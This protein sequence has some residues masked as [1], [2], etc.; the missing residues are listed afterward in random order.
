LNQPQDSILGGG[1]DDGSELILAPLESSATPPGSL[2]PASPATHRPVTEAA[3]VK[4]VEFKSSPTLIVVTAIVGG[5]LAAAFSVGLFIVVGLVLRGS[6]PAVAVSSAENSSAAAVDSSS[7]VPDAVAD[8]QVDA[9]AKASV[10]S[11]KKSGKNSRSSSSP[12]KA[13]PRETLR[14]PSTRSSASG[15]STASN[16]SKG[17]IQPVSTPEVSQD[18]IER[19]KE[20]TVFVSVRTSAG[21]QSGSGFLL[22]KDGN[23]GIVVTNAHVVTPE[24]GTLK[25]IECV[26]HSGTRRE[27]T[28]EANIKGQDDAADL[29]VLTV[30]HQNLPEPLNA[31]QEV[32]LRE[33]LPV[34]ILGFP[35]GD[36]LATTG[37]RPSISVSKVAISSIRRDAYDNV[38]LLQI[39]GGINPGN[40]G[41]PIVTEDGHL[42]GIAVAKVRDA[43]IGF[44]IP[45]SALSDLVFGRVARVAIRQLSGDAES[46]QY[47]VTVDLIDPRQNIQSV[48]MLAFYERGTIRRPGPETIKKPGPDGRWPRVS[49]QNIEQKLKI[50]GS[51]AEGDLTLPTDPNQWHF[52]LRYVG[53]DRQERFTQPAAFVA[54]RSWMASK[55]PSDDSAKPRPGDSIVPFA[56]EPGVHTIKLPAP[57]TEADVA[58]GGKYLILNLPSMRK[59]A[60]LDLFERKLVKYLDVGGHG[61]CTAGADKLIFVLPSQGLIQRWSLDT[62]ER[63]LVLPLEL[64]Y[65]PTAAVM[66]SAS[67]GPVLIGGG[68]FRQGFRLLD[69][70]TLKPI[71]PIEEVRRHM[72]RFEVEDHCGARASADGRVFTAWKPHVSPT[73]FRVLVVDGTKLESFHEH[74]TVGVIVPNADG[75]MLFTARGTYT[76][77]I[78][79]IGPNDSFPVPA[80][81][82]NLYLRIERINYVPG[83]KLPSLSV[84]VSGFDG[85]L[86]TLS[87]VPMQGA[88]LSD[89]FARDQ[90]ALDQRIYFVPEA[91][92]I[93]TLPPTNDAVRLREF[94]VFKELENSPVEYLFVQS[95][96]PRRATVGVP[97]EYQLRVAS[98]LGDVSFK[99]EA[100]PEGMKI[101]EDGKLTWTPTASDSTAQS[102]IILVSDASGREIFHSFLVNVVS[103]RPMEKK[104]AE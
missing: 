95:S 35:F 81:Q 56:D 70:D 59:L 8:S 3:S 104:P 22:E 66:G 68:D 89:F 101:S 15:S 93:A 90:I 39:D 72:T 7:S 98:K 102:V 57:Y 91:K 100:G 79:L 12:G 34:L 83:Q 20:A 77:N 94:D 24:Q 23:R 45:L 5:I 38:A 19:L 14:A 84:H 80:V 46:R 69:L 74:D 29:A 2:R 17:A 11:S 18:T 53:R 61:I 21:K 60:V 75:S 82:G 36:V 33:T 67:D 13:T 42:V 10:G 71:V 31:T 4:P 30:G 41:G 85:P 51:T 47:Q 86:I 62:F 32:A 50:A 43:D 26:F 76:P 25:G 55:R 64:E 103:P 44:A 88:Y 87:D 52:Q 16:S 49:Q 73:G 63:E 65:Q 37:R 27:F 54:N 78:K 48:E 92:V 40:S 28:L 97:L 58:A 1:L 9:A 6:G 96:P 99:L